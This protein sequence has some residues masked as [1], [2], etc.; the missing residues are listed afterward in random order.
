[1]GVILTGSNI[2]QLDLI[3]GFVNDDSADRLTKFSAAMIFSTNYDG[4]IQLS[5]TEYMSSYRRPNVGGW[6]DIWK[7]G[8]HSRRIHPSPISAL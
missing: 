3:I 7:N 8:G 6:R 5:G 1:M 2:E 4:V